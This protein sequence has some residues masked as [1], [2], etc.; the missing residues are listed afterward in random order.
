MPVK[1][2]K[3]KWHID[4]QEAF[5]IHTREIS[6]HQCDG[7]LRIADVVI[8]NLVIECQHSGIS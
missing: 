6:F 8:G 3:T 5:P 2:R 1:E 4:W 7:S